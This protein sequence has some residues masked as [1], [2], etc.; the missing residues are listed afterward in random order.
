MTKTKWLIFPKPVG[1][2]GTVPPPETTA[3]ASG[4]AGVGTER[5]EL[6]LPLGSTGAA[7]SAGAFS[8]PVEVVDPS[9]V[10]TIDWAT[11]SRRL[12]TPGAAD[13]E[14][15]VVVGDAHPRSA[16]SVNASAPR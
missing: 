9:V 11:R 15:A 2:G 7:A 5:V 6:A 14:M 3:V 16:E 8:S 1:I 13:P 10:R 12:V 4:G